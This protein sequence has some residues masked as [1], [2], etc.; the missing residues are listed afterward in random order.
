M[1]GDLFVGCPS[2][3]SRSILHH[4]SLEGCFLCGYPSTDTS[5]TDISSTDLSSTD[6][7]SADILYRQP[8]YRQPTYLAKGLLPLRLSVKEQE[9]RQPIYCNGH[10]WLR[11]ALLA[12]VGEIFGDPRY[13]YV[14][15]YI[16]V[17]NSR[18]VLRIIFFFEL[19]RLVLKTRRRG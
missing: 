1:C 2:C 14:L 4:L 19:L 5:S 16:R 15:Q 12:L 7:S 13:M 18:S 8:T 6:I 17:C 11:S 3:P 9:C 10:I